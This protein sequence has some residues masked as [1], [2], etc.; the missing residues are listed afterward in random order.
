L[1]SSDIKIVLVFDGAKLP[2]KKDQEETR[3]INRE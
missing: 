3:R 1:I 2:S